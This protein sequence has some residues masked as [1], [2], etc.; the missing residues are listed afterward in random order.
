MV[1]QS[2][3]LRDETRDI[4][5]QTSAILNRTEILAEGIEE[6]SQRVG[7][8]EVKARM[9]ADLSRRNAELAEAYLNRTIS[10]Y[11]ETQD[12]A[13]QVD[14]LQRRIFRLENGNASNADRP[15][16]QAELALNL[17]YNGS[18]EMAS[19]VRRVEL[20]EDRISKLEADG[21]L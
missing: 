20:L 21:Q 12:Y 1:H 7:I 17:N 18:R 11:N 10:T 19:L 14:A 3:K 16:Y 6:G 15:A 5:S 9:S 13:Q 4:Y 2:R 8:L